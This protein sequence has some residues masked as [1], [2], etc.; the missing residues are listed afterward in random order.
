VNQHDPNSV[1]R[2]SRDDAAELAVSLTR[3][4]LAS[5]NLNGWIPIALDAA[6][7]R[8]DPRPVGKT[9]SRW[10]VGVDWVRDD[11]LD[12][13]FDGASMVIADLAAG[14]AEWAE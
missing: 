5:T 11:S 2:L 7:C 3:D 13:V 12:S 10:I 9:P 4:L 6:P 14:S 8:I 1:R